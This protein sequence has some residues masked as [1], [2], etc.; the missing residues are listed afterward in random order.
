LLENIGLIFPGSQGL[1]LF[2]AKKKEIQKSPEKTKAKK[3]V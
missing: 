2:R 3:V 1:K